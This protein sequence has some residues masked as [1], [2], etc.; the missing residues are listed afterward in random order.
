[1]ANARQQTVC[2][3]YIYIY[4]FG[5]CDVTYTRR[6]STKKK[7]TNMPPKRQREMSPGGIDFERSQYQ[8]VVKHYSNL[9]DST[10][11]VKASTAQ[12]EALRTKIANEIDATPD[13]TRVQ[14]AELKRKNVRY[15]ALNRLVAD[16]RAHGLVLDGTESRFRREWKKAKEESLEQRSVFLRDRFNEAA[17]VQQAYVD[18]LEEQLEEAN[19]G[20]LEKS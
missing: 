17:H 14:R 16:N 10:Q 13:T 12:S 4:I 15:Q 6:Q 8:S 9:S 3:T 19:L 2:G 7:S 20:T 18:E 1:M 11:F 5:I